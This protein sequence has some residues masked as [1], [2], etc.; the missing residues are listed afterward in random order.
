[1]KDFS[2][3]SGENVSIAIEQGD[4]ESVSATIY[5]L[6]EDKNVVV[7]ETANYET[8]DDKEIAYIDFTAPVV[9]VYTYY[10]S[11]NFTD[12]PDLIYPDPDNCDGD[13]ELPSITVCELTNES[14]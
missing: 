9:G 11:E 4:T 1:M 8:V 10:F 13:C 5:L 12:E 3:W 14:S 2:V 6:D 7:E